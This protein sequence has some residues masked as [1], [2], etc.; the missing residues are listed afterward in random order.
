MLTGVARRAIKT[1]AGAYG[2]EATIVDLPLGVNEGKTE[3]QIPLFNI[4][5]PVIPPEEVGD[6]GES[7]YKGPSVRK[8]NMWTADD[9]RWPYYRVNIS[10]EWY[11]RNTPIT[12]DD[13][14]RYGIENHDFMMQEGLRIYFD[15]QGEPYMK[16]EDPYGD[17]DDSDG[18][19]DDHDTSRTIL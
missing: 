16:A 17:W 15:K 9:E 8:K 13:M 12:R 19:D 14:I 11:M 6:V 18:D 4:I 3:V 7:H 1:V 2:V 5:G 10:G